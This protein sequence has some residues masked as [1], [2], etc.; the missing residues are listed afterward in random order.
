MLDILDSNEWQK[1]SDILNILTTQKFWISLKTTSN[2]IKF[3]IELIEKLNAHVQKPLCI[4]KYPQIFSQILIVFGLILNNID[5]HL[6]M[7]QQLKHILSY[8]LK[9]FQFHS[10]LLLPITYQHM[11][12]VLSF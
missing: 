9:C 2:I 1:I 4:K 7:E 8:F 3:E 5:D 11:C 6:L 12:K 10:S